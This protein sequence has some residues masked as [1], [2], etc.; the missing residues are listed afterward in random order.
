MLKMP[1]RSLLIAT[2]VAAGVALVS[3]PAMAITSDY[4]R[5]PIL[6]V[7]GYFVV[8]NA[9]TA[10][11]T[12]MK[13]KLIEDGWPEEYIST[14]SFNDVRGCNADHVQE[15]DTWVNDLL[16]KTYFDR[17]DIVCHSFGCLNVLAWM[18]QRCGMNRVRQYVGLAGAVHGTIIA[19]ADD[20]L[21]I[22][23]AG[24]E[25]CIDTG[26][27]GW[28]KNDLIVGIN[29]CDETPGNVQ[30][31]SV[32]SEY[33][34]IIWPQ[35]GSVMTGARNIEVSTVVE[36]GG[37]FLCDECYEHVRTALTD[38]GLNE[39]GPSWA[40]APDCIPPEVSDPVPEVAPDAADV[41][42]SVEADVPTVADT[43]S[44]DWLGVLDGTTSKDLPSKDQ[45]GASDG[46]SERAGLDTATL[47]DQSSVD[48]PD[49]IP[50]DVGGPLPK[51]ASGCSAG[52]ARPATDSFLL[53][54][55]LLAL[56]FVWRRRRG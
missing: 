18:K 27:G 24:R 49:A 37:I 51:I 33:D 6:M 14:P 47:M 20:F 15:I 11:W 55:L 41:T 7:H 17:V 38:G 5:T 3:P 50:D 8:D 30:Y 21:N 10:T 45:G 42:E 32:W 29:A 26:D 1:T 56:T 36:H 28:K 16:S 19:C 43:G 35:S 53:S 44:Q 48:L 22:S 12:S 34:E 54:S 52:T 4:S 25:M 40:C 13:K 39:D 31:T 2:F 23:C 46:L 9:G